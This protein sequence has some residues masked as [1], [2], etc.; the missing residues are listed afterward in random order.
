[1][2][3]EFRTRLEN[4][5]AQDFRGFLGSIA[6]YEPAFRY[7]STIAEASPDLRNSFKV[8]ADLWNKVA[9]QVGNFEFSNAKNTL[10][11]ILSAQER[12]AKE[13]ERLRSE[14]LLNDNNANGEGQ[15]KAAATLDQ[16]YSVF[17]LKASPKKLT[18]KVM[19]WIKTHV[20]KS[21]QSVL[22]QNATDVGSLQVYGNSVVLTKNGKITTNGVSEIRKIILGRWVRH[23]L[24]TSTH[25]E[26]GA[27]M[28]LSGAQLNSRI[29]YGPNEN[30]NLGRII[31]VKVNPIESRT[32]DL[33]IVDS[34]GQTISQKVVG[35]VGYKSA[36]MLKLQTFRSNELTSFTNYTG[37]FV[38]VVLKKIES[39]G[40]KNQVEL[41]SSSVTGRV[42]SQDSTG[43]YIIS[44]DGTETYVPYLNHNTIW[45]EIIRR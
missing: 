34:E 20:V 33:V 7:L 39:A 36:T 21:F 23:G 6:N 18:A 12:I 26:M 24:F 27:A 31:S 44:N 8:I 13:I 25:P 9:F 32:L 17:S 30:S 4:E 15:M 43:I 35:H 28:G 1:M 40:T 3:P 41:T 5:S 14:V 42:M 37:T 10:R 22:G 38:S 11:D 29:S 19:G 16:L 45:I 2:V